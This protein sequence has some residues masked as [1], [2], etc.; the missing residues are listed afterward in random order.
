MANWGQYDITEMLAAWKGGDADALDRLTDL[1]YP[2]LRQ[3]ARRNL[4]RRRAGD[5]LDS[6]ALANEAYIKLARAGGIRCEN[7][8][9]FLALCSQIMRRILVDHAR[10]RR[11]A[12]RGGKALQVPLDEVLLAVKDRGIEVLALNEALDELARIDDRKSRVIE[13]RYFGGL[14]I[15]ETAEVLEVSVDTVKRDFR[16]A[17]AWLLAELAGK[18][19]SANLS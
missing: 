4:E 11:F 7:R 6:A 17:R 15:E 10:Q 12:K 14:S 19:A 18:H 8:A 2:E 13:L 5:S 9:H 16:M 1:V 3:I